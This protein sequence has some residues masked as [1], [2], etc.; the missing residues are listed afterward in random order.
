VQAAFD[1]LPLYDRLNFNFIR[2]IAPVA[3]IARVPLVMEPR[4][5]LTGVDMLHVPYRGSRAHG[6]P[7]C[8]I[9][10]NRGPFQRHGNWNSFGVA[11]AHAMKLPRPGGAC[12]HRE[13]PGRP[14]R[15]FAIFATQAVAFF[16]NVIATLGIMEYRRSDDL[17]ELLGLDVGRADHLAPLLGFVAAGRASERVG[18]HRAHQCGQT[19]CAGGACAAPSCLQ[20]RYKK[21]WRAETLWPGYHAPH[22]D[23]GSDGEDAEAFCAVHSAGDLGLKRLP[24]A[25]WLACCQQWRCDASMCRW[26]HSAGHVKEP[27]LLLCVRPIELVNR[28]RCGLQ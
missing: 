20:S 14:P 12:S 4:G 7:L 15:R 10:G 19:A 24:R 13:T 17:I 16:P 26:R 25:P 28:L 18:I 6:W 3:S 22:G 27:N 9:T 1:N 2:D 8:A 23:V 11:R 5:S 21:E